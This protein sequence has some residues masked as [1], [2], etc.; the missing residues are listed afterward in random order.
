MTPQRPEKNGRKKKKL[1]W[2]D[3][4]A[5]EHQCEIILLYK[6]IEILTQESLC[7]IKSTKCPLFQ[8]SINNSDDMCSEVKRDVFFMVAFLK[9]N[10]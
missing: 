5:P 10:I 6:T 4:I 1:K 8:F 2:A 3:P 7:F 9:A